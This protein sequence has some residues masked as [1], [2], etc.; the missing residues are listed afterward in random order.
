MT[1]KPFEKGRGK[2]ESSSSTCVIPYTFSVRGVNTTAVEKE[3]IRIV[4][5]LK[6]N[7]LTPSSNLEHFGLMC[8]SRLEF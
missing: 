2:A 3:E 7:K 5:S 8:L 1:Q 4:C 6:K